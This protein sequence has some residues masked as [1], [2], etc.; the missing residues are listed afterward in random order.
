MRKLLLL[1]LLLDG[2]AAH[3]GL[4]AVSSSSH[5]R[6]SGSP[7][8]ET[9]HVTLDHSGEVRVANVNLQDDSIELSESSV[10]EI[11]GSPLLSPFNLPSGGSV[12]FPLDAGNHVLAATVRGKPG[13]GITVTFYEDR[14]NASV[15]GRGFTV[16]DDGT[17]TQN[18]TGL[19]WHRNPSTPGT[20]LLDSSGN[21]SFARRDV[22]WELGEDDAYINDLNLGAFGELPDSGN[23]GHSDW[24]IPTMNEL[25]GIM[26]FRWGDNCEDYDEGADNCPRYV[27]L[28]D[29]SGDNPHEFQNPFLLST[30]GSTEEY[31][32]CTYYLSS[33]WSAPEVSLH[34]VDGEPLVNRQG[35]SLILIWSAA[36]PIGIVGNDHCIWPVRGPE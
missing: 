7:E 30:S 19:I 28:S 24:R 13:G 20:L 32:P 31:I 35:I 26:D 27:R 23:A 10:L 15:R 11:N 21:H 1:L 5:I 12:V 6:P 8:T 16:N 18:T 17:V 33:D 4:V 2:N 9:T 14:P 34:E 36:E 3:A 25:V 29:M 22:D